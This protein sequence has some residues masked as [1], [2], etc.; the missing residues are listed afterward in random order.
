[1]LTKPDSGWSDF[2]LDGTYEYGLSYLDEIA[3]DWLE[4]A[5]HGLETMQPF[6]VK[7]N[8]E[9][10]HFLCVVSYYNC[11]IICENDDN[12]LLSKE[13]I[14]TDYSHTSMIDFCKFLY[15]DIHEYIEEWTK[16]VDYKECDY[17]E[18][19]KELEN[20]LERL[21]NLI[22]EKEEDFNKYIWL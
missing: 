18:H 22:T 15:N 3:S 21:K 14:Y 16:F 5:I 11:H 1:M 10:G 19:R 6:C 8:M 7:G 4:Q 12:R 9:P 13:D 17:D 20:K 2:Q